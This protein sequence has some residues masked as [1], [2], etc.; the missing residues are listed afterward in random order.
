MTS[1]IPSQ[2][3]PDGQRRARLLEQ[4]HIRIS[5]TV[6]T[7]LWITDH[8]EIRTIRSHHLFENPRLNRIGVLKFIYQHQC[9][10]RLKRTTHGGALEGLKRRLLEIGKVDS[11]AATLE[12]I[13]IGQNLTRHPGGGLKVRLFRLE[14]LRHGSGRFQFPKASQQPLGSGPSLTGEDLLKRLTSLAAPIPEHFEGPTPQSRRFEFRQ[15]SFVTAIAGLLGK[16]PQ[17]RST[18]SVDGRDRVS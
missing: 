1:K 3:P 5:K 12:S 15:D 13:I 6:D 16:L 7:L 14:C 8:A 9:K 2:R 10:A 18:K 4:P 11:R 17:D